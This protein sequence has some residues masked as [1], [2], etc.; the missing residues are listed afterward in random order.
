MNVMLLSS[1]ETDK[2]LIWCQKCCIWPWYD[3][4]HWQ[5]NVMS[6][7]LHS[8]SKRSDKKQLMLKLL[9]SIA[10][11]LDAR[12][13]LFEKIVRTAFD[14]DVIKC[15]DDCF[16]VRKTASDF[17]QSNALTKLS[18]YQT[19]AFDVD[20]IKCTLTIVWLSKLH[21]MSMSLNVLTKLFVCQTA[22]FDRETIRCTLTIVCCKN[23][24]IRR[25]LRWNACCQT[26]K[27]T[28]CWFDVKKTAFNFER[29]NALTKLSDCQIAAF[30]RETIRC[31]LTIV[32]DEN[33][34]QL[35]DCNVI[36]D[37]VEILHSMLKSSN[38]L[39]IL[40]VFRRVENSTMI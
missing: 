16:D 30:D 32:C 24:L 25:F 2:L 5:L 28:N 14:V 1:Y 6:N 3:Q 21:L 4:M 40:F 29:S 18:D 31:T 19:A 13:R 12:W 7:M 34:L 26:V 33:S 23:S 37:D 36:R 27:R 8:T 22:A 35:T 38:A 10:M 39:T 9:H 17:K 15:I 11:K 20:V